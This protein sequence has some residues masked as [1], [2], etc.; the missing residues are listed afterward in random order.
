MELVVDF[1]PEERK[2]RRIHDENL[3]VVGHG[4]GGG[5]K[6]N[7]SGHVR[8]LLAGTIDNSTFCNGKA[9][10]REKAKGNTRKHFF[11]AKKSLQK[12]TFCRVCG[13]AAWFTPIGIY[14]LL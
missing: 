6:T 9:E 10:G 14:W 12:Y 2:R 11:S 3:I 4:G 7:K 1:A 8:Q 13:L 5:L